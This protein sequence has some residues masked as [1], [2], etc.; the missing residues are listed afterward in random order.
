M[1]IKTTGSGCYITKI[2]IKNIDLYNHRFLNKDGS[3][4]GHPNELVVGKFKSITGIDE[5]RFVTENLTSS[6]IA[7]FTAKSK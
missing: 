5:L 4:F 6:D 1:N 3:S 2:R 7:Y